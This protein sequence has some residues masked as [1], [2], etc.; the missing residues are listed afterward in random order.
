M[1]SKRTI[2]FLLVWLLLPAAGATAD[3]A[4]FEFNS[5]DSVLEGRLGGEWG[6]EANTFHGGVSAVY[7]SDDY[8]LFALDAAV[9][10]TVLGPETFFYLG[11]KGLYG[12]VEFE[13]ED[14]DVMSV[15]FL[16]GGEFEPYRFRDLPVVVTGH[17]VAALGPMNFGD[18]DGYVEFKTTAGV[19]FLA[20]RRGGA[21][22]GYRYLSFDFEDDFNQDA[23]DK[24]E[25]FFGI[26]FRY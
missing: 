3:S 21:F 26:R 4:T 12:N 17:L 7:D 6:L 22:I 18:N 2:G 23:L 24:S 13:P 9:G 8:A 15:G 25:V 11:L 14:A 5:N 19:N 1:A 20:E 10:N 16:L